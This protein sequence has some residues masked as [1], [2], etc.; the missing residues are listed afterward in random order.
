MFV[1]A[2]FVILGLTANSG[3]L[4]PV[5]IFL[6]AGLGF[7]IYMRK[8]DHYQPIDVIRQVK[9]YPANEKWIA[10]SVDVYQALED[11]ERATFLNLCTENGIGLLCVSRNRSV[12][13]IH[14]PNPVQTPKQI[15]SFLVY[16]SRDRLI[17]EAL[18]TALKNHQEISETL[19]LENTHSDEQTL[20]TEIAVDASVA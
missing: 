6:F 10:L 3:L 18:I 20:V 5:G 11:E 2:S 17:R 14:V 15:D 19:N 12:K 4:L 1:L 9:G 13:I 7:L 16:Y 8:I